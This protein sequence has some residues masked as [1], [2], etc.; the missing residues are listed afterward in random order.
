MQLKIFTGSTTLELPERRCEDAEPDPRPFQEPEGTEPIAVTQVEPGDRQWTV[1]RDLVGYESA[2]EVVN[3]LGVVRF[4]EID[5]EVARR[6]DERYTC[7]ADQ[8]DSIRGET[9]WRMRFSRDDW[10][11][12]TTTKTAGRVASRNWSLTVPRDHV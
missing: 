7:V 5:L 4:D 12:A 9:L 3:D 11:V 10:E 1:T 6:A 2:L 8:F